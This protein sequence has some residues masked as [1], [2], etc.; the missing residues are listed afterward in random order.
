M[1]PVDLDALDEMQCRLDDVRDEL[2]LWE[3]MDYLTDREQVMN[4]IR[5]IRKILFE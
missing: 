1:I 3:N 2:D 5:E 4:L